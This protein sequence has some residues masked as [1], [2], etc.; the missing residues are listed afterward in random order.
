MRSLHSKFLAESAASIQ[1][2]RYKFVGSGFAA[3]H[4]FIPI[5]FSCPQGANDCAGQWGY[6]S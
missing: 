3:P 1:E 6:L 2:E 5:P 4:K